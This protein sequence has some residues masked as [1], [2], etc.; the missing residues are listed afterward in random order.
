MTPAVCVYTWVLH[1][2]RTPEEREVCE[3]SCIRAVLQTRRQG[4]WNSLLPTGMLL[5]R[6]C[7]VWMVLPLCWLSLL[8]GRL[9]PRRCVWCVLLPVLGDTGARTHTSVGRGDRCCAVQ[10]VQGLAQTPANCVLG[11]VCLVMWRRRNVWRRLYCGTFWPC[12]HSFDCPVWIRTV[13]LHFPH[14]LSLP[15]HRTT[16]TVSEPVMH[17]CRG[18]VAWFWI[19]TECQVLGCGAVRR[20]VCCITCVVSRERLPQSRA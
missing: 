17:M 3:K 16:A 2:Q 7:V 18:C 12:L 10:G 11:C 19:W 6:V 9:L 13:Q 4:R 1:S 15:I 5:A 14:I 8:Q 20:H